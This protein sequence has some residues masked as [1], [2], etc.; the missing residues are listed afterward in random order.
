MKIV[1]ETQVMISRRNFLKGMGI[2]A[3]GAAAGVKLTVDAL[4]AYAQSVAQ[5]AAFYQ[6]TLGDFQV[7][8]IRDLVASLPVSTLVSNAS[9][10][11]VNELLSANSFPGGSELPNN[12][13]VM[14]V[15]TGDNLVLLDTGLGAAANGQLIP[16]LELIG[17]APGDITH[18]LISHFHPDHINGV[19]VDGAPAF[20]NAMYM[21]AQAEYDL[22]TSDPASDFFSGA[23]ATL[24]PVVDAG[25]ME[26]YATDDELVPGISAVAAFGHT[27]SHHAF[28]VTSG[29]QTLLNT[30]DAIIHPV[31][32]VQRTDWTFGFDAIPEQA[33]ETRRALLNRVASE[34]IFM[35]GYHFPFPGIGVVAAT[36]EDE[37]RFTPTS[38]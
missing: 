3:L 2:G 30:V 21:M 26:F 38:Y 11:E 33:I 27:P 18:V 15:N 22:I 32:S 16:T 20:P 7:T 28:E 9:E 17:I 23:V 14:L 36:G 8:V 12:I 35:Y 10:T 4:P 19:A 5:A 6:T 29:G 34:G 24:Q 13:K 37:F 31:I 25:I 1:K